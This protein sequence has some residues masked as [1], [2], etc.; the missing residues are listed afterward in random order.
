MR[1]Q[2]AEQT[3]AP[4]DHQFGHRPRPGRTHNPASD[5]ADRSSRPT[6]DQDSS[7]Y[8]QQAHLDAQRLVGPFSQFPSQK[9]I[10]NPRVNITEDEL[11]SLI[12]E[13]NLYNSQDWDCVIAEAEAATSALNFET[14]VERAGNVR[15]R[16]QTSTDILQPNVGRL[17][18]R[19]FT[20][21]INTFRKAVYKDSSLPKM[22]TAR[23]HW[24]KYCFTE[25]QVSPIRPR[26]GDDLESFVREE[27]ILLNFYTYMSELVSANTIDGYISMVRGWHSLKVGY[28]PAESAVFKPTELSKVQKGGRRLLPPKKMDRTPHPTSSFPKM[29]AGAIER[30]LDMMGDMSTFCYNDA[31]QILSEA[32]AWDDLVYQALAESMTCGLMRFS[33]AVAS[34]LT[35][36][37]VVHT[38]SGDNKRII[39]TTVNMI[40]L[41]KAKEEK[42]P[43]IWG[44]G[45]GMEMQAGELLF[46]IMLMDPVAADEVATTPLFR[47]RRPHGSN[48][49]IERQKFQDWYQSRMASLGYTKV[50]QYKTHSFRIGGA[51]KL[52]YL[53]VSPLDI[54]I[55]G[56]WASDIYK[57]YCRRCKGKLVSIHQLL[58]SHRGD[59][60][61][62]ESDEFF[63]SFAGCEDEPDSDSEDES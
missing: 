16:P 51:T 25:A 53:N 40:P 61:N 14:L 50:N 62:V 11:D 59:L 22:E 15:N 13:T 20:D 35:R 31:R 10:A 24:F 8:Q 12:A 17:R 39:S 56:R 28:N 43:L 27:F 3:V 23:R 45:A 6:L 58:A 2:R 34:T 33:E 4:I 19:G 1:Q 7:H 48:T 54:Q 60:D 5:I 52:A 57:I 42:C 21:R 29:R 49:K 18:Q 47:L 38:M 32:N 37:D 9:L 63:D 41:K 26:V 44:S 30:V 36:A 55:M 46:L